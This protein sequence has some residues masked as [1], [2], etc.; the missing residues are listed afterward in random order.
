LDGGRAAAGRE[1]YTK[2]KEREINKV[3]ERYILR[4]GERERKR[5]YIPEHRADV[6]S[7]R[8]R[9]AGPD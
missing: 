6:E 2:I 9:M 5:R 8:R 3:R 4:G 7:D 1:K